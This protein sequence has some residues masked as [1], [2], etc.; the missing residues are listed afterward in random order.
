MKPKY[1]NLVPL[2]VLFI[3]CQMYYYTINHS[4]FLLLLT[5]LD[6]IM[7]VLT[8]LEYIRIKRESKA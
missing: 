2:F 1:S 7:I 3:A 6:I 8:I 5:V 4:I